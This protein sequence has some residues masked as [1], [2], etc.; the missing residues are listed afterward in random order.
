MVALGPD[1]LGRG[2]GQGRIGFGRLL[3]GPHFPPFWA[4]RFARRLAAV[5]VAA[6]QVQNPGAAV[7]VRKGLAARQHGEVKPLGPSLDGFLP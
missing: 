2:F 6:G 5:G 1:P 3:E 4:D 7:L